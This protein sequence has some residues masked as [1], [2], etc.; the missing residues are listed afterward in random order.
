MAFDQWLADRLRMTLSEKNISF[1]EKKMMG[2]LC[3]MVDDK[4]CFGIH[5]DKNTKAPIMMARVGPEAAEAA[6]IRPHCLPMEFTGR[7]MKGFVT[8]TSEGL[9]QDEDLSYWVN[10]CL[11]YNPLAKRSKRKKKTS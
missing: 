9:D 3:F 4:M 11:A 5:T 2:G 8:I 7:P 1:Q 10:L 6:L